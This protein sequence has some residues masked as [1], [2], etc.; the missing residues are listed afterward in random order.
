MNIIYAIYKENVIP[1]VGG[2]NPEGI[3]IGLGV[4]KD[5]NLCAMTEE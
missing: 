4:Y 5:W 1:L 2:V 3:E